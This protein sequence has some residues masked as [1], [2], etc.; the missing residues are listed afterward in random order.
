[1]EHLKTAEIA[2]LRAHLTKY[3]A[4]LSESIHLTSYFELSFRGS[5]APSSVTDKLLGITLEITGNGSSL[6][7][8]VFEG[9]SHHLSVNPAVTTD[10]YL[11]FIVV[12]WY[13]LHVAP[14]IVKLFGNHHPVRARIHKVTDVLY[15]QA[16]QIEH[17]LKNH[18][19]SW[20][21]LFEKLSLDY[22]ET[23][24]KKNTSSS[25]VAEEK[26]KRIHTSHVSLEYNDKHLHRQQKITYILSESSGFF[27]VDKPI[28]QLEF[29]FDGTKGL[30]IVQAIEKHDAFEEV[31]DLLL[32]KY[33]IPKFKQQLKGI[34]LEIYERTPHYREKIVIAA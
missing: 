11:A 19:K 29:Y 27:G 32:N 28:F 2:A 26:P 34:S 18:K 25:L 3:C 16:K 17:F 9:D 30:W 21:D 23:L 24:L 7:K 4:K 14:E 31:F 1:M 6:L 33:I 5:R 13:N 10:K 8:I 12:E 22:Y 15:L 20:V